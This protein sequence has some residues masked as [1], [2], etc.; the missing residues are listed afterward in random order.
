MPTLP[1]LKPDDKAL[2]AQQPTVPSRGILRYRRIL[3]ILAHLGCFVG[4][5][6]LA[7][8]FAFDMQL[9][10]KWAIYQF[11]ILLCVAVPVKLIV[12]ARFKQYQGWWR[13]VGLADLLQIGKASLI[14]TIVLVALWYFYGLFGAHLVPKSSIDKL[15]QTLKQIEVE[16]DEAVIRTGELR[17]RRKYQNLKGL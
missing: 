2:T 7:F 17:L 15:N 11:P 14:S 13:Y 8:L 5:M 3:I 12:F 16:A 6:L 9:L 10:R 1:D 4:A